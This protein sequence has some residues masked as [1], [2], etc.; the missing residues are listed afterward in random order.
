M[1]ID[2]GQI[3]DDKFS[4]SSIWQMADS[5]GSERFRSMSTVPVPSERVSLLKRLSGLTVDHLSA[6]Q[7]SALRGH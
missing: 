3:A 4:W 5:K 1:S 6:G 2:S 7:V